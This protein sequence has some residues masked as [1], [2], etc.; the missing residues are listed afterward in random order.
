MITPLKVHANIQLHPNQMAVHN[1]RGRFK[2]IKAG[3]RWG[4]SK[5]AMFELFQWSVK[6]NRYW[7]VAE[8]YGQA[9]EIAWR[10]L[11]VEQE[12][13]QPPIIPPQYIK[14]KWN[15]K[16]MLELEWGSILQL[17]GQDNPSTLRGIP[18]GGAVLDERSY[19][20]EEIWPS[21]IRGQLA[22]SQ[23]PAIFISSPHFKGRNHF[24]TACEEADRKMKSGDKDFA[25]FHFTIWDN[26]TLERKEIQNMKDNMSD[27]K[28]NLEYM[29]E[30]SA[31]GGICFSEFSRSRH[32]EVMEIAA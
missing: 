12:D 14:N 7:Y 32:V 15:S 19:H 25:Y 20:A 16:L 6:P 27:D 23:G 8:T 10:D 29:A 9:E 13:G 26:P 1:S 4:K 21:I 5:L 30:E 11:T 3:K 28:W 31:L 17:K 22:K 2:Y 18:L 24:T